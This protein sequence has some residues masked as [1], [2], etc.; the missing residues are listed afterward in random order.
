MTLRRLVRHLQLVLGVRARLIRVADGTVLHEGSFEAVSSKAKF[1]DWAREDAK[2]L[3]EAL[4][5]I[6]SEIARDIVSRWLGAARAGAVR[7]G[8][9]AMR[10]GSATPSRGTTSH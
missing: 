4:D 6:A 9:S 8:G 2:P 3:R 1:V 10:L 5:S 7:P